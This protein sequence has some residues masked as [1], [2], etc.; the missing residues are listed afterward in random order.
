MSVKEVF[1]VAGGVLFVAAFIPYIRAILRSGAKPS[2]ATWLIWATL[3]SITLAGMYS[4][5]SVNGQIIGAVI[6][7]WVVAALALKKGTPGWTKLDK[8][9][10]TGAVVGI[11]IWAAF[12]SPMLAIVTILSVVVIAS[13]PTFKSAWEDP[14]RENRFAWTIY[15]ISC[16][17]ALIGVSEWDLKH[18]TQPVAFMVIETT[19]MFI[20]IVR[21]QMLRRTT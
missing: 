12:K 7:A 9:C 14:T 19:M 11:A 10:L 6:G 21:P 20:L 8:F 18:A 4:E 5:H 1:S 17:C 15:W 16:V 13:I 3:D 2:K